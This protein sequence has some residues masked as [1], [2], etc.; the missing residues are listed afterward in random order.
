MCD[1]IMLIEREIISKYNWR[2]LVFGY[3]KD[4]FAGLN[5]KYELI[6][7]PDDSEYPVMIWEKDYVPPYYG[8]HM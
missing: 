6:F 3:H 1:F 4:C 2:I 7:R 5:E 8:C